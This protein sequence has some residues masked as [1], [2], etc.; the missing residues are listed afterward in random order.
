MTNDST[1]DPA[2]PAPQAT[3]VTGDIAGRWITRGPDG[4]TD[5]A[6][7]QAYLGIPFAAPPIGSQR[8]CSPAPPEA[9][10]GVRDCTRPGPAA[11]QIR[12][13]PG[14]PLPPQDYDCDEDCLNLNV[15]TPSTTGQRPVLFWVHGGSYM[16]GRG[17][18]NNGTFLSRNGDLV[19]VTVNYRMGLLGFIDL[20]WLDPDR[21]GSHNL[22]IQ[23]QIAALRWVRDNIAQFGGDPKQVTI[24]GESAGAGSVLA[25]LASPAAD[26]LFHQVISQSAPAAFGPPSDSL[27]RKLAEHFGAETIDDL[28]TR[29]ADE[30]LEA[31]RQLA[32]AAIAE[33]QQADPPELPDN[34]GRF[35]RPAV[36]GVTVT[37]DAAQAAGERGVPILIGTNDDEGS[38][39]SL[40]LNPNLTIDDLTAMAEVR[41]GALRAR[42]IVATYQTAYPDF[43]PHQI[44][45]QWMGDLRFWTCT[46]DVADAAVTAGTPVHVYRFGWKS[47]GLGGMFGAMHA[48]EIPFIWKTLPGW[49]ALFGTTPP[50][51]LSDEMHWA[52]INYIKTGDPSHPGI[53]DWA[54]YNLATR[55]TMR[56]DTVTEMVT[57]PGASTHRVWRQP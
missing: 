38:L 14:G 44:A 23:D 11:I 9:W 10:N 52:W 29:S 30:I 25:L 42:E 31:Q 2:E 1:L 21:A 53:G 13:P 19:V 3:T 6:P 16:N 32:G 4:E 33:T 26:G 40:H 15:Y 57:D 7:I 20:A 22:G 50:A 5:A 39:F 27:A 41:V 43:S 56:F 28:L 49:D 55:P 36:D 51:D 46:L 45:V 54:P 18:N 47:Q 48:M 8:W 12:R 34:T 24:C 17:A 35:F 37:R